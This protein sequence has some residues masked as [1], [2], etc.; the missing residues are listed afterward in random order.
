[1]EDYP[2][3]PQYTGVGD[4]AGLLHMTLEMLADAPSTDY[5]QP[6]RRQLVDALTAELA[7]VESFTAQVGPPIGNIAG[8]VVDVWPDAEAIALTERVRTAIRK[9]RGEAALQHS[10]GRPHI[11]L[12]YAYGATSSDRLNG[13]LRNEI[14]PR[15][16]PLRVDRVHLLDVT[17]TFADDVGGWRMSWEPVAE[18]P[19]ARWP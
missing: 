8:V 18:I 4:G 12:G 10:G 13:R 3:D 2:I 16:V 11:S 15:Q 6:A 5:D 14:T 1:M 17:W 9:A 19:L 7:D